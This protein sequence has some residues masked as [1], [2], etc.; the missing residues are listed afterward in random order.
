M[1]CTIDIAEGRISPVYEHETNILALVEPGISRI[2]VTGFD[3]DTVRFMSKIIDTRGQLIRNMKDAISAIFL[4][5]G[6]I[7]WPIPRDS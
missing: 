2:A 6:A 1:S 4:D 3:R 7:E 5:P